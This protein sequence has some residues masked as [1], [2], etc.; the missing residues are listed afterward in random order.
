MLPGDHTVAP[1]Y[2]G[3]VL[4]NG[5]AVEKGILASIV[6]HSDK[7]QL[8]VIVG[9]DVKLYSPKHLL[10]CF[11]VTEAEDKAARAKFVEWFTAKAL[12]LEKKSRRGARSRSAAENDA[13]AAVSGQKRK[14]PD[15][16]AKSKAGAGAEVSEPD[17][18]KSSSNESE[19]SAEETDSEEE[20]ARVRKRARARSSRT[21]RRRAAAAPSP[22]RSP[23]KRPLAYS[24]TSSPA[25]GSAATA[26]HPADAIGSGGSWQAAL[27]ESK[28]GQLFA[29]EDVSDCEGE[30]SRLRRELGRERRAR[31]MDL[32]SKLRSLADGRVGVCQH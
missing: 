30:I 10:S 23:S 21:P 1:L 4:R 12:E 19:G 29:D 3:V 24:A 22:A 17:D 20:P 16:G 25:R 8:R 15:R 18:P 13:G 9:G 5:T 6:R 28:L 32:A 26:R 7:W 31:A 2:T 14:Q 27:L 11:R